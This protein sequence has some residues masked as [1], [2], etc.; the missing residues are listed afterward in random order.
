M[1]QKWFDIANGPRS[2]ASFD[3]DLRV[4]ND[5]QMS[6]KP[7]TQQQQQIQPKDADKKV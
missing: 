2:Q 3:A 5:G 4:F 6:S 7:A 1:A